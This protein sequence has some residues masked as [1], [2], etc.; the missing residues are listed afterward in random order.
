MNTELPNGNGSTHEPIEL[1]APETVI[2]TVSEAPTSKKTSRK[3]KAKVTSTTTIVESDELDNRQ[4][5]KVLS[6]VRNGNFNVRMPVDQIGITGKICDTLNEIIT[7][8]ELLMTELTKAGKTIGKQG[9]L[10]HRVE[11]PYARGAWN[12]GVD[13]INGLS[14]TSFIPQSRSHT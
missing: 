8:N 2:E 3:T 6:D 7:L 4:L 9:K 1:I 14:P 5:L 11:L 10:T 12:N 13:A